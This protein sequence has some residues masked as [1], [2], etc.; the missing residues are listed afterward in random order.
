MSIETSITSVTLLYIQEER[1]MFGL[2]LGFRRFHEACK[3]FKL[4]WTRVVSTII[5]VYIF[6]YCFLPSG[7]VHG[8]LNIVTT[9]NTEAPFDRCMHNCMR[10]LNCHLRLNIPQ[11]K[12]LMKINWRVFFLRFPQTR[13][14]KL[15]GRSFSELLL[16]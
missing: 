15:F 1:G 4:C 12:L 6:I 9:T 11:H 5:L 14:F 3:C 16:Y 8:L 2:Q 7:T 13:I 10:D